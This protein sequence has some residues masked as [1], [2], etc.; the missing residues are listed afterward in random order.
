MTFGHQIWQA[1]TSTRFDSIETNQAG[2]GDVITSRSRDKVKALCLHYHTGYDH[3]T[4]Q[5]GNLPWCT[6]SDK[7]TWPFYHL[8]L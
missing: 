3:Q 4:W 1:G 2:A 8:V 7:V 6:P 5:D